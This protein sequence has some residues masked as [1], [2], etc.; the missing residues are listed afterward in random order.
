[1][2]KSVWGNCTLGFTVD[3][4]RKYDEIYVAR[5]PRKT[6]KHHV[7]ANEQKQRKKE[8]MRQ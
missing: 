8:T 5:P 2:T 3:P 7:R 4:L 1:M 6:K